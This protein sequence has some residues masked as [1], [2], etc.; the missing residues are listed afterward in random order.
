MD[1]FVAPDELAPSVGGAAAA[2]AQPDRL[3]LACITATLWVAQRV[4]ATIT[5]GDLVPPYATAR[6]ACDPRWT[7]AATIAA[8]RFYRSPDAPFGVLGGLGDMAVTVRQSIPEAEL[9]LQGARLAA[10]GWG[11]G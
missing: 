11:I 6:I 1:V 10:A 3:A 8:I 7:A 9:V 5:A 4:G 2:S